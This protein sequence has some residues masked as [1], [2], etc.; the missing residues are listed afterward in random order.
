[1]LLEVLQFP[2]PRLREKAEFVRQD[3][4]TDELRELA[5]NMA[6]TMYD[7]PGIGL[8]ATQVGVAK[9]LI[10]MDLAWSEEG[11]RRPRMLL[12]PEIVEREGNQISEQEGCLS[13]PEFN[14]D[15]ERDARVIVKARTF[16]WEEVTFDA[17]GLESFCFQHEIDHL[18]GLLFIDRISRLKR[19]LYVRRRK[20]LLRE[21]RS[22]A[23]RSAL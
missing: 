8:A 3:E 22:A 5:H 12:N 14:A 4:L 20:K 17:T 23:T 1:M 6:E 18:D 10:V 9:R 13:V 16:D 21:E 7:E 2:D 15:V 11:E 19:D